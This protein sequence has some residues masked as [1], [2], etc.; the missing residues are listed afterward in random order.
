MIS[1]SLS[2]NLVARNMPLALERTAQS[3]MAARD[4]A[5]YRE[6]IGNIKTIDDFM[7]DDRI[8]RFALKAHGL[9]DMAYAKAFI[10]K[11]LEGGID[12]RNSFA[13]RLSDKR[14]GEL[15]TAFNFER[16]GDQTTS[17]NRATNGTVDRFIRQSLEEQEGSKNEGVRLALY[18]ERKLPTITSAFQILGDPALLKVVQ[19][20]LGI[21]PEMSGA[22]IDKQAADIERRLNLESLKDP[23]ELGKF[24]LR[25]TSL[26][27]LNSPSFA[28]TAPSILMGGA[29]PPGIG[30]DLLMSIQSIRRGGF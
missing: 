13:N 18:F 12:D 8:Y 4:I 10:R 30:T 5:Y 2:Y 11:A 22:N 15:V 24:M 23:K 20:A 26:W 29:M 28:A 27:E 9:E 19:T 17:F 1:T 16:Y 14:Y 7:K 21:P 25:F 6:N 3:P